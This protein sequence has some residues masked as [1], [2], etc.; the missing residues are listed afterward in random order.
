MC[1]CQINNT[2]NKAEA[3]GR[4]RPGIHPQSGDGGD[5]RIEIENVRSYEA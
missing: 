2:I 3:G 5:V 4:M 1:N